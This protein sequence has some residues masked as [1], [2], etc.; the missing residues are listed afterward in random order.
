M[1]KPQGPLR[2]WLTRRVAYPLQ[3]LFVHAVV[4][5]FGSLTPDRA[6]DLGGWIGRRVGPMLRGTRVA[7][8]NLAR[9]FPEKSPAEIE[10][11]ILEMWDNLGRTFAEYPHLDAIGDRAELVG[12]EHVDAMRD[13]GRAGIMVSGHLSNWEMPSVIMRKRGVELALVYRA[14]NN[15]H[16]GP[17]LL[18]MRGAATSINIPKGP[19]GARQLIRHLSQGG[20]AGMLIDQKMNDGIP[21]PFFGRDAMTAPAVAQLGRRYGIPIV[22]VR[23][24]RIE[25]TRF[26]ITALPPIEHPD[27]G[28]RGAEARILMER[29]NLLL[30][31]WIRE[32]P[33]QWLWTHRRWPD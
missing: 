17:L 21:I 23:T 13:D 9:A 4:R 15:P 22:P 6:S 27:V 12:A 18:R 10:R 28:D 3:G 8:R 32:R 7:R 2:R 30:E 29:L 11:I 5:F 25:G 1:A 31:G 20:H 33:A 24:E 14:P 26:R 16:V 19:E